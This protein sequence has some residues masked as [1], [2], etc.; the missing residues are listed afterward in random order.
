[1]MRDVEKMQ[2]DYESLTSTLLA[3]IRE[4]I[5][6]LNNRDFPNSLE[7]I[8]KELILFKEYMTVEKP[9]K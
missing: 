4:K 2:D 5:K 8:Q 9:P 1:M 7:G 6:S 3:W